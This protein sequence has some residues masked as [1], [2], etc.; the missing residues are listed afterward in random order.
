MEPPSTR[1]L[2]RSKFNLPGPTPRGVY[3]HSLL[4][5]SRGGQ[6]PPDLEGPGRHRFDDFNLYLTCRPRLTW[7]SPQL[8]VL[9]SKQTALV[10]A[11]AMEPYR[12]NFLRPVEHVTTNTSA[13]HLK[14]KK[15]KNWNTLLFFFTTVKN[16]S[17]QPW[18]KWSIILFHPLASELLLSP[19]TWKGKRR[20][21]N[22]TALCILAKTSL[23]RFRAVA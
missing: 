11:S 21:P 13:P 14:D 9:T 22:T 23:P 10:A 17:A 7:K 1:F 2:R 12:R 4:E 18:Q 19:S 6:K 20:E 15:W 16:K 5:V 8:R 3:V